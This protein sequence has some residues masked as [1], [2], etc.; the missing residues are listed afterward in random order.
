MPKARLVG[1]TAS[2]GSSVSFAMNASDA[3]LSVGWY[4][5][6][7]KIGKLLAVEKVWPVM[8]ALGGFD[9]SR[10]MANPCSCFGPFP[11]K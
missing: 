9:A 7:G 11:P 4:A 6:A 1:D 3:P 2:V 8:Y 5:P 10:A